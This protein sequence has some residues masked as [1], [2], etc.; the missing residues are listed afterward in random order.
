[1]TERRSGSRSE[2]ASAPDPSALEALE[3]FARRLSDAIASGWDGADFGERAL[4]LHRLQVAANPVYRRLAAAAGEPAD[5]TAIPA[6]PTTAFKELELTSVPPGDRVAVFHSSG[7]TGQ[8]PSRHFHGRASLA[9]YER[10]LLAGFAPLARTAQGAPFRYLSLTPPASRV[11]R[12]SLVHMFEAVGRRWGAGETAFVGKVDPAE[13]TWVLDE[14]R[15]WSLLGEAER[16]GGPWFLLG[17]AFNYVHLAEACARR[18][19]PFRLGPESRV[20][21]TGGYKGRSRER[22]R[23]E[24]HAEIGASLGVAPEAVI[25]EYGMS[26]L[27]SQAYDWPPAAGGIRCFR[28]PPWARAWLVSPETGRPVGDGGVG[29]VRV[30]DLANVWSVQAIQT[31]DLAERRGEGFELRGRAA[32]AEPRGCSLM[33]AA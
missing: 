1:M 27:S 21:E 20:L 5:W 29:L 25:R 3:G 4:E 18:G 26:E 23:A 31:G 7:T 9:L 30:L 6:V 28:F 16:E 10:S 33:A 22:T 12:S 14:D 32:Q 8:S 15:L 19:R 13:G 17:T 24:L 11:P 2:P